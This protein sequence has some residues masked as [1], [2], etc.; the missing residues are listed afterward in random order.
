MIP[1]KQ[2]R[3]H[4]GMLPLSDRGNCFPACIASILEMPCEEVLQIQEYYDEAKWNERLAEW[5]SEM[6]YI[7]RYA[8]IEEIRSPD[9][10]I[11]VTGGSPRHPDLTHVT[12][13]QNGRMVHDP[14][15]EG[16]GITD[17][18]YFEIIERIQPLTA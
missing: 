2:T 3:I 16:H 14:H 5:L 11:L 12:I 1:V 13:Y 17:E 18:R 8:T 10:Y 9:K 6:G 7:W 4:K 15:P